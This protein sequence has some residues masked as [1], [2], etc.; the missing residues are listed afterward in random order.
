MQIYT[1]RRDGGPLRIKLDGAA[2]RGEPDAWG[3]RHRL[4]FEVPARVAHVFV[5]IEENCRHLLES[6]IPTI[7]ALWLANVRPTN[8]SGATLKAKANTH[9]FRVASSTTGLINC[10]SHRV[11]GVGCGRTSSSTPGASA[12]KSRASHSYW[13]SLQSATMMCGAHSPPEST[14]LCQN[15]T[16]SP[17]PDVCFDHAYPSN[18]RELVNR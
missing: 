3:D 9:G 16:D 2:L 12:Y 14:G 15:Q 6:G 7:H 11:R 10:Q 4:T 8:A 17:L 5:E 1:L 13:K 18:L